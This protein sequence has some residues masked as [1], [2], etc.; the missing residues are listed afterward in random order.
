MTK[1]IF[2][3]TQ[4]CS[5][6]GEHMMKTYPETEQELCIANEEQFNS[7]R[8]NSYFYYFVSFLVELKT[9]FAKNFSF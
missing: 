8:R 6:I 4:R 2:E 7:F 3:L 5:E 9:S 1:L